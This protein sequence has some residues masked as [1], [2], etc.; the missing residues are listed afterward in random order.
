MLALLAAAAPLAG[1]E[2]E[3]LHAPRW[4]LPA[5]YRA[6]G[7]HPTDL[8]LAPVREALAARPPVGPAV[9]AAVAAARRPRKIWV[10]YLEGPS[11]PPG[12]PARLAA[13]GFPDW[14]TITAGAPT[15]RWAQVDE[16]GLFMIR[17]DQLIAERGAGGAASPAGLVAHELAH[18]A[19]VQWGSLG[20]PRGGHRRYH[21]LSDEAEAVLV[22][23]LADQAWLRARRR[24]GAELTPQ[25][26]G[27]LAI[28]LDARG[29]ARCRRQVERSSG[30]RELPPGP[31]FDPDRYRP[32]ADPF[33]PLR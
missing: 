1:A 5:A 4:P 7:I 28:G 13:A 14:A 26:R 31:L 25:E 20:A 27:R 15:A 8:S 23:A 24:E 22:E 33:R 12:L 2:L 9:L 21:D 29:L 30:Y 10:A 11:P 17:L 18:V 3:V 6:A 16:V 19:Q 32:E